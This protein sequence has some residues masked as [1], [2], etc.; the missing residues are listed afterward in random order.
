MFCSLLETSTPLFGLQ[1]HCRKS[2]SM[3]KESP[4]LRKVKVH[5]L[6]S[7]YLPIVLFFVAFAAISV[8]ENNIILHSNSH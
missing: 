4:Y 3:D 1:R 5:D 8:L 7:I 6:K 2:K